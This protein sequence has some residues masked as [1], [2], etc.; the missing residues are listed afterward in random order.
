ME[1]TLWVLAVG[2]FFYLEIKTNRIANDSADLLAS[3]R[4]DID[5]LSE[6]V[7]ALE[8]AVADANRVRDHDDQSLWKALLKHDP[9]PYLPPGTRWDPAAGKWV[10]PTGAPAAGPGSALSLAPRSPQPI[11][12]AR[13]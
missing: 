9:W 4:T 7:A 1:W 3:A 5:R 2:A 11:D 10:L 13:P 6:Q 12:R 8:A